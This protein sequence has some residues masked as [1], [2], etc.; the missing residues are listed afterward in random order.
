M[1]ASGDVLEPCCAARLGGGRFAHQLR[2][3]A[4]SHGHE[5]LHLAEQQP[6]AFADGHDV[7][8]AGFEFQR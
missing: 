1:R 7:F 8:C 2:E 6:V 4:S 5:V 3:L